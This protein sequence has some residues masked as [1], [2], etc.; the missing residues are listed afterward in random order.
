MDSQRDNFLGHENNEQIHE[1][2]SGNMKE[3]DN[4]RDSHDSHDSHDTN[5]PPSELENDNSGGNDEEKDPS[6]E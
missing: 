4:K 2:N 5:Q 1:Y 3:K 6:D